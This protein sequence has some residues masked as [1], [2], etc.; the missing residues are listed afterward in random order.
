MFSGNPLMQMAAN[1]ILDTLTDPSSAAALA[2]AKEHLAKLTENRTLAAAGQPALYLLYC[3]YGL[4]D[5]QTKAVEKLSQ[6][7]TG[8]VVSSD[9]KLLTAKR[10]VQPWKFDP[11]VAFLM[12]RHHLQLDPDLYK[13]C[14]WPVGTSVLSK[15][16]EL[17]FQSASRTDNQ[18][19]KLLKTAPD[20]P[21]SQEYQDPDSGERTTLSL[22]A[23]GDNDL[24]VLQLSGAKFKPLPFA[25]V[26]AQS[27]PG[28]KVAL[29]GFPFGLNQPQASPQLLFTKAAT[30][31]SLLT[32]EHQLDPGESGAPLLTPEGKVLA[33]ASSENQCILIEKARALI[34]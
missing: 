5:P 12:A 19:L 33:L 29:F 27:G 8:F 17:D 31:G 2:L 6:S 23:A 13:L 21:M 34:P 18:T 32:L 9:G 3:E 15:E 30:G 26:T 25:D 1:K 22:E 7:G 24:A 11:Q 4:V 10:V 20:S 14:A 28:I 16:R